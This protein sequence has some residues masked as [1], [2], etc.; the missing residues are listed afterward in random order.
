MTRYEF[1]QKEAERLARFID[2]NNRLMTAIREYESAECD[3]ERAT[4]IVDMQNAQA[5]MMMLE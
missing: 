5:A 2:A 1:T 3:M 4:A